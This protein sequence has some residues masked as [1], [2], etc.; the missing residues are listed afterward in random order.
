[1]SVV[2]FGEKIEAGSVVPFGA[3]GRSE[4]PHFFNQAKLLSHQKLK[5]ALFYADEVRKHTG[6]TV[7][8]MR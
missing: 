3:S 6:E 1:M 4:S 8:L 7:S 2:E 5:P